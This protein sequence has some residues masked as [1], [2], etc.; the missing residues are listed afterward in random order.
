LKIEKEVTKEN[1]QALPHYGHWQLS[2]LLSAA[3]KYIDL[4]ERNWVVRK[5][6]THI[7]E[8]AKCGNERA[9]TGQLLWQNLNLDDNIL[10]KQTSDFAWSI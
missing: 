5:Q 4:P 8:I 7:I 2:Q 6:P 3:G 1:K 10:G 9:F